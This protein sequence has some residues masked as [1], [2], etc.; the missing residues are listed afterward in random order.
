MGKLKQDKIPISVYNSKFIIFLSYYDVKSLNTLALKVQAQQGC[1]VLLIRNT[2][3][4]T[5]LNR[6]R[7]PM[8]L[9]MSIGEVCQVDYK[10]FLPDAEYPTNEK[11]MKDFQRVYDDIKKKMVREGS[12]GSVIKHSKAKKII[13]K[14]PVNI[15]NNASIIY[16]GKKNGMYLYLEDILMRLVEET[17]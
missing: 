1:D 10:I 7:L 9:A 8:W 11:V 6:E 17:K 12:I 4:N 2:L 5:L 13:G 3:H 14:A 15:F 16:R